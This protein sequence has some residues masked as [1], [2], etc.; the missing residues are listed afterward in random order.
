MIVLFVLYIDKVHKVLID[1]CK[2]KKFNFRHTALS[3]CFNTLIF[4]AYFCRIDRTTRSGSGLG[5]SPGTAVI[6]QRVTS[7]TS[8]AASTSA[9]GK[10]TVT[11][12]ELES[13]KKPALVTL[14]KTKTKKEY[15]LSDEETIPLHSKHF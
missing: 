10:Y 2:I 1:Y 14:N 3:A 9:S 13:P 11:A 8:S 15:A 6:R 4:H 7:V 12:D 5:I